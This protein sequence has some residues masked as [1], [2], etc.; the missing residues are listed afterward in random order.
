M[1]LQTQRCE[2]EEEIT[3]DTG[4]ELMRALKRLKAEAS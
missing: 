3:W 4:L 2:V 1:T